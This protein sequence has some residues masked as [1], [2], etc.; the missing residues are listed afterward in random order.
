MQGPTPATSTLPPEAIASLLPAELLAS[1]F[2]L[3]DFNERIQSSHVCCNWRTASL[4][5]PAEL[6]S[7]IKTTGQRRGV[8]RAQLE[9]ARHV[10]V[11]VTISG[12]STRKNLFA[13]VLKHLVLHMP[14][15]RHLA[16]TLKKSSDRFNCSK[17]DRA[18]LVQFL[19]L[20][21]APALET[22]AVCVNGDTWEP[23]DYVALPQDLFRVSAPR[24]R[25][26]ILGGT[27]HLPTVCP[28]TA[29]VA[30]LS[31]S[32]YTTNGDE[33]LERLSIFP[34]LENVR[35][36]DGNTLFS[37]RPPTSSGPALTLRSLYYNGWSLGPWL[38]RAVS[39]RSA[40]SLWMSHYPGVFYDTLPAHDNFYADL[41]IHPAGSSYFRAQVLLDDGRY[42][43]VTAIPAWEPFD[44]NILAR[45]QRL[46]LPEALIS[47][48]EFE[49]ALPNVHALTIIL[50]PHDPLGHTPPLARRSGL[51]NGERDARVFNCP[52][53][54]TLTIAAQEIAW[55]YP[56]AI[57]ARWTISSAELAYII[58]CGL[59]FDTPRLPL[60][61][62]RGVELLRH[63]PAI[64]SQLLDMV[65]EIRID[66]TKLP[67]TL[68]GAHRAE[69]FWESLPF[70]VTSFGA[71]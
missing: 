70:D 6:W 67:T 56:S 54:S 39:L 36:N 3:L 59:T 13:D 45:V 21:R 48:S 23:D 30:N 10:P 31:L 51:F 62:L 19:R 64:H 27:L 57:N 42:I 46:A 24:L 41:A 44:F 14:H 4:S 29:S 9:R 35:I 69:D 17:T 26:V 49:V 34:R 40:E 1:V 28:V 16:V 18:A 11:S 65:D 8:F 5:F 25:T 60:L 68:D 12:V 33:C 20:T 71:M 55:G 22:L 63:L 58:Q 7:S 43:G 53:L 66:G 52:H 15:T 61:M 50:M 2:A 38:S 32:L 37:D 47:S